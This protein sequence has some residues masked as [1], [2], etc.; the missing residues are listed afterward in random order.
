MTEASLNHPTERP[1]ARGYAPLRITLTGFRGI[2]SGL[3]RDVLALDLES[4]GDDSRLVAIAGRNGCGKTTLI[5]NLHPYLVMPSRAG[6]DGL[7]SFSYYDHVF[8]PQSEKELEW[9][10]LGR[11]YKTHLVFRVTGKRRTEAFLFVRHGDVWTPVTLRDGTPTDGKVETYERAVTEILGPPGTFFTSAFSAQGKRPLCSYRN[12]EVKSLL[13]DLLGLDKVRAMGGRAAE[14]ARLLK[15]GLGVIRQEQAQAAAAIARLTRQSDADGWRPEAVEDARRARQTAATR[16]FDERSALAR[17]DAEAQAAA[18]TELRRTELAGERTRVMATHQDTRLRL[19]EEQLRLDRRTAALWQRVQTRREAHHHHRQAVLR[20]R[21][22]LCPV[23]S[24]AHRVAWAMRRLNLADRISEMRATHATATQE[25]VG[26]LARLRAQAQVLQQQMEGIDKEAGQTALRYTDLAR[27]F[28]LSAEVPCAGTDLQPRCKL[29]EDTRHAHA[30]L[31]SVSG[32]LSLLADRK[33]ALQRELDAID[34]QLCGLA[35]AAQQRNHAERRLEAA[36]ARSAN[37]RRLADRN[38]EVSRAN[39]DLKLL[40]E[41]L[42]NLVAEAPAETVDESSERTDIEAARLMLSNGRE[43]M[44]VA[45]KESIERIKRSIAQ[46]PAPFDGG[47]Q[48]AARLAV[49]RAAKQQ[50][51]AEQA[52]LDAV[53]QHEQ[54]LALQSQIAHAQRTMKAADARA[55][56]AGQALGSWN[57][58]AKCLSNDGV[59]ALD[60]DDAGPT[61]AALAND[62]LLACYGPRFTLSVITQSSTAKGELREDFDIVVHDGQRGESKSLKLVSGGERVWINESLT[63][64]IALYLAHNTGRQFSTLFCDEADGPLDPDHKR[65]FMDMKREVLRL[66]GYTREYYVSQ[67]PEL[68]AMADVV[69]DLDTMVQARELAA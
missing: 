11:R 3:G 21:E 47:R 33:R 58:L 30:L 31:P 22:G 51:D 65:M 48:Q 53:R 67:T 6:A 29:L 45:L 57:L 17:I 2:R 64:A 28:G 23:V 18:A 12:G 62:L 63:R 49:D 43:R 34:A 50:S 40:E 56:R 19:E 9:A 36:Q 39:E 24:L 37:L 59:I 38:E 55:A 61:L 69:I 54:H 1:T 44:E 7:G 27:R 16:V 42:Q 26:L 25:R 32:Q 46:L 10:H 14:T 4:L 41:Q 35:D 52:E 15:A 60:I 5:D 66:A 20:Q 8:L 13:A 68:T